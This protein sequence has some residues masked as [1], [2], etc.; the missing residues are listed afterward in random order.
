VIYARYSSANQ[1]EASIEQQ[2][3][4]CTAL[5]ARYE[6]QIID[7]YADKAISGRTDNRPSFQ[8]MMRDA[9]QG[10]FDYVLAWKSSR[11]GRNMLEA[12]INDA[13]LREQGVTTIYVEEDFEDNAA[14]RFALR[15]MMNVN[16][17][18]SEALAE[19]VKRGMM[20]NAKKCMVNGKISFGFRKGSDGRYEIIPEE[21]EIIREIF[22]RIIDGWQQS[23]ILDDLNLRG[24][25]TH[26]GG[27]WKR[28][29]FGTLLRN[30]QY[31]GV[32]SYNGIRIEGGIPA[33]LDHETFE[34][35]Q[36]ILT[37]KNNPRGRKRNVEDY[38]LTGKLF[39]GNCGKPMVGICGTSKTGER[40]Y[41]YLCQGKHNKSGC[42]KKNE[43]KE[44]V[45]KAVINAVK[46][47]I[48]D[49]ETIDWLIAGYQEFIDTMRGQSAVKAMEKELAETEKGIE[50]LMRAIEMGIITDTTKARMI[51]LEEKKKDLAARIRIESRMLMDLNPD[52]L[53]FSIERF[54]DKNINDLGYQKELINTFVKAIYVY[55]D[56][57]K[58][59][60]NRG[61]GDEAEIP[62][63]EIAAFEGDGEEASCVRINEDKAYQTVP[64]R[65]PP[66]MIQP[67]GIVIV[68]SY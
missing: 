34:E 39:C 28:Q 10:K 18:Y 59:V 16:Q 35:V 8:R 2:V 48:M 22:Y 30:E 32:Y 38:L 42:D 13:A 25:R 54:R 6:L 36:T 68:V 33:I 20:D 11:M 56:R 64:V 9:K 23:D 66:I 50:N 41:Y 57:L 3:E 37:T 53:R 27:E 29:S 47:I 67:Y 4:W 49:D 14:G 15:N 7:T 58:I 62:F 61:P 55:D 63:E 44:K 52:Q 51:E 60:F 31:I 5:A 43:R 40:H 26:S 46:S 1:R 45:E 65:T 21:A 12:M 17:F 19:D 24:I